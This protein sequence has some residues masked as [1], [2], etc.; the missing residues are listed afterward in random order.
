MGNLRARW[1]LSRLR[2]H[3]ATW[4]RVRNFYLVGFF[5][6][7]PSLLVARPVQYYY[8]NNPPFYIPVHRTMN[9][10]VGNANIP[11]GFRNT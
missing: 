11:R 5:D 7:L 1:R 8:L 9:R 6:Y 3:S 4:R 2:Q 10:T